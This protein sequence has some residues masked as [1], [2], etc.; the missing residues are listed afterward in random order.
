LSDARGR[1]VTPRVSAPTSATGTPGSASVP[2]RGRPP[3]STP[4]QKAIDSQA[5]AIKKK[6]EIGP[7]LDR[8]GARLA[9]DKRRAGFVDDENGEEVIVD[10]E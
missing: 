9:N 1:R 10:D 4:E 2:R 7:G 5:A 8:G 6:R 3:K